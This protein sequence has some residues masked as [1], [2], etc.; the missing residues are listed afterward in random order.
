M[1]PQLSLPFSGAKLRQ[2]R[3]MAGLTL[4]QLAARCAER[5][6]DVHLSAISKVEIGTNGPTPGLLLALAGA[7]ECDVE[8]LLDR[9]AG[10]A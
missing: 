3:E 8:D 5:G 4:E 6:Y 1:P 9:T 7:L 2:K 10:A